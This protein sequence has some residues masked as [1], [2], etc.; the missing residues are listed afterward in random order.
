MKRIVKKRK[1]KNKKRKM[2]S[3]PKVSFPAN[4]GDKDVTALVG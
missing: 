3:P 2:K 4:Y 1:R